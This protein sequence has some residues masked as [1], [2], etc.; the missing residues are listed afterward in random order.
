MNFGYR[1]SFSPSSSYA[2]VEVPRARAI[3]LCEPLEAP[4][5]HTSAL[6]LGR[7]DERLLGRQLRHNRI[8]PLLIQAVAHTFGTGRLYDHMRS[9][10]LAACSH[11]CFSLGSM[12]LITFISLHM[13]ITACI[14]VV[15]CFN[16]I[17]LL[18]DSMS[19]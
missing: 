4:Q 19:P 10:T 5:Q 3:H 11:M 1:M 18:C 8:G 16:I 17:L 9:K 13:Y 7:L 14:L 15:L 2:D 12:N 6:S